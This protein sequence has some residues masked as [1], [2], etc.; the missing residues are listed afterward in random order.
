MAK[1]HEMMNKSHQTSLNL[2]E[3]SRKPPDLWRCVCRP[4]LLWV[5]DGAGSS[6]GDY[7]YSA[8]AQ[9]SSQT[10]QIPRRSQSMPLVNIDVRVPN[11]GEGILHQNFNNS[12]GW[13]SP[14]IDIT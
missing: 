12:T 14:H 7:V 4:R 5:V 13:L 8:I 1:A 3:V 11:E 10:K 6:I 2:L 9:Y